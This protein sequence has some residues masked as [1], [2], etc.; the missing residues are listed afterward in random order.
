[1][2]NLTTAQLKQKLMQSLF[3]A[4]GNASYSKHDQVCSEVYDELERRGEL[5]VYTEAYN[6]VCG[7]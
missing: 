6:E 4:G 2:K 3:L 5:H 1:M 7:K